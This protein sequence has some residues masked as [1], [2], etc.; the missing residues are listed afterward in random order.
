MRSS[1]FVLGVCLLA[2]ATVAVVPAP[3]DA[4]GPPC[5]PNIFR[6]CS[7]PFSDRWIC[8]AWQLGLPSFP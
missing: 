4:I 7:C 8:Q 2:I 6:D 5:V 1:L 3:V